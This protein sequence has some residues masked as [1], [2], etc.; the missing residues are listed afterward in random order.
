MSYRKILVTILFL[1]SA[2]LNWADTRD[3][4]IALFEFAEATYPEL[5]SPAAPEIQEIQGFYV[6]Y[7][8]DS[9]IYLGV[10]GDNIWAL[11][12]QFGPDPIYVGKIA[13]LISVPDSDIS[14][15]LLSNRRPQCSYYAESLFSAVEDIKRSIL[16]TGS[17]QIEVDG[18]DCVFSSNSIPNHD[19][20]DNS[21]AFATNVG[22]VTAEFRIPTQPGFAAEATPISL[23]TDN[24]ILL[25]GV[26]IDLLA[27][28]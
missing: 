25:N 22:A 2:P 17:L 27:V 4:A 16:Y 5:L 24:A 23:Q 21:A 14:D 13:D 15:L 26:K 19:F 12:P 28:E 10:L 9:E 1:F 20:N 18:D 6:R 3:N 8:P 11:G 7:Y